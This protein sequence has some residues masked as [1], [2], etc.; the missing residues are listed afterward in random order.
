MNKNFGGLRVYHLTVVACVVGSALCLTASAD[1]GS[2]AAAP[3]AEATA[4]V[5]QPCPPQ[6]VLPAALAE[7]AKQSQTPGTSI[8]VAQV[9][10][11]PE[12]QAYQKAQ[13]EQASRDWPNL[14][15][16]RAANAALSRPPW[17]I[18][19]GDSITE[20]WAKSDQTL[21]TDTVIGRG[22]SGQTTPQILLR[23]YQDVIQLHPQVV[24]IM[25]GTNDLA[26]NTGLS[27]ERAVKDNVMAMVELAHV[28]KIRVVLA[29]IPPASVFPWR[30]GMRPAAEIIRLNDWLRQYAHQSGSRYADYYKLLADSEGGFRPEYSND[31]VHP[32]QAGY[33]LMR[34]TALSAIG[35]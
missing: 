8:D 5:A 1:E 23:F 19:I 12:V 26:G 11:L 4:L 33:A 2:N 35:K 7:L 31:G 13:Q 14:C 32:N 16:Y 3:L 17:A 9:F 20:G 24:H 22:I 30:P 25:A 29:S 6:L 27:T 28:N 21:F 18:F 34:D 10:A 15:R